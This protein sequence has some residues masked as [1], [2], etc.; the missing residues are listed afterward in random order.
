M[1]GHAETALDRARHLDLVRAIQKETGGFTEFV[2]LSFIAAEAP[3]V[4]K[5]L[6]PGVRTVVTRED[7]LRMYAIARLMLDRWIPNL[8]AAWVKQGP[9]LAQACLAAG[10]NDFGGTLMNESILDFGRRCARPIPAPRRD[11]LLDP[12]CRPHPRRTL[13]NLQNAPCFRG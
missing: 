7:V 13:Y 3:M 8:E 6:V 11:A 4:S 9:K 5:S 10:A 12:R 2:P 1:Y